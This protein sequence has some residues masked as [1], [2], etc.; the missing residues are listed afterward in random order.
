MVVTIESTSP[1]PLLP[2]VANMMMMIVAYVVSKEIV[3]E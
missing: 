2:I 3:V 1:S